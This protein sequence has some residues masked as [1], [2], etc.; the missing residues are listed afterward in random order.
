MKTMKYLS[1]MLMMLAMSVCMSSCGDDDDDNEVPSTIIGKWTQTNNAG[2]VITLTFNSNKTGK[3]NYSYSDASG[4]SN[5]NFEYEFIE[6][7][8]T[9]TIIN[10]QL[11]G[12]YEVT[13]TATTLRLKGSK[14]YDFTKVK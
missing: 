3:I 10:S 4:D 7:D 2:T 8:R 6:K 14:T 1:M 9:L 13:L 12:E 5:E 11:N